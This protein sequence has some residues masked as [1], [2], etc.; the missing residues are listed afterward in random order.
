MEDCMKKTGI[1]VLLLA[2]SLSA[3][4]QMTGGTSLP[5]ENVNAADAEPTSAVVSLPVETAALTVTPSTLPPDAAATNQP[6]DQR[7]AYVGGDGNIWLIDLLTGDQE[8]LTSDGRSMFSFNNEE[9]SYTYQEPAWS[10]DGRFLAY[11]RTTFT[12]LADRTDIKE[13]LWLYDYDSGEMRLL[14]EDM[15]ITGFAWK[16][17]T[18]IIAYSEMTDPNY[19]TG[20]GKVDASLAKGIHGL[21]VDRGETLELVKAQ[22]FSLVNPHFSADGRFLSFDEVYLM[23]GRGN[24]AYYDFEKREYIAWERPIGT[25]SWSPDGAK[26]LYDNLTYVPNGGERIFQNNRMGTEE[27]ALSPLVENGYA[28]NPVYSPDGSTVAY[29]TASLLDEGQPDI[30]MVIPAAGGEAR[31]A[32]EQVQIGTILW[33]AGGEYLVLSAGPYDNP[34]LVRVELESGE[35]TD[36]ADGWQ[37]AWQPSPVD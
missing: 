7:L 3:C 2:L 20:R 11:E 9:K 16:P 27:E 4:T 14:L 19:F 23:E 35:I 22:G 15:Q 12:P 28:S 5:T 8:Q 1:F 24:F 36:L 31:Q 17:Q 37:P 25:Y 33:S 29:K 30:L 6:L 10:S 34:Q 18:H 26:I 21:D 32:A 13:S